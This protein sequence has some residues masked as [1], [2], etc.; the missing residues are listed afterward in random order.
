MQ[1]ATRP[2]SVGGL[3]TPIAIAV[4]E[5]NDRFLI[6]RRPEGVALAGFWEFPGGKIH[7]GEPPAECAAR[8][9]LEETGV[10]VKVIGQHSQR[11]YEYDHG[12]VHLHF[13]R[14]TPVDPAKPPRAPFRWV[15][16][17]SLADYEF[18]PANA[19]LIE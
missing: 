5:Q 3:A 1:E 18:P 17:E 10:A 6:G 13:F 11:V 4:V 15:E 12:A 14:C 19:E 7:E 9:C 8:E 16:R 2:M